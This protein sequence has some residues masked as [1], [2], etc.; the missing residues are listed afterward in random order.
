MWKDTDWGNTPPIQTHTHTQRLTCPRTL[1]HSQRGNPLEGKRGGSGDRRIHAC[2]L[3]N[4][5]FPPSPPSS[6]NIYCSFC[7]NVFLEFHSHVSRSVFVGR[8][9]PLLIHLCVV[10][11]CEMG[12]QHFICLNPTLTI[13]QPS[14]IPPALST[15]SPSGLDAS[16]SFFF[17]FSSVRH[18]QFYAVYF[19]YLFIYLAAVVFDL[20]KNK[21]RAVAPLVSL[22]CGGGGGG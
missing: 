16:L 1:T 8:R 20:G 4:T 15:P 22:G 9:A 11:H 18:P 17:F 14:T 21:H 3:A 5:D 12:R 13:C 2:A 7:A 6:I 10:N 19:I